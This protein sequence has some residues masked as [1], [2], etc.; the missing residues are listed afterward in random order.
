MSEH[1]VTIQWT[2]TG[3]TLEYDTFSRDHTWR[4]KEGHQ[5]IRASSAPAYKGNPDTIDPEDAFVAAVS[6][7]HMLTFLAIA[8]KRRLVVQ[9]YTDEPVGLLAANEAGRLAM[10]RV[11]LRPRVAFA[12]GSTVDGEAL[13][14]LHAKAHENCFIANSVACEVTIQPRLA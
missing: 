14:K 8:A 5:E 4:V 3:S 11:E 7:C 2:N 10:T 12:P 1:T 9:S 6:S 13:A